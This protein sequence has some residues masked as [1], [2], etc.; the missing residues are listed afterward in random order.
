MKI[1][2]SGKGGAGKTTISAILAKILSS[3]NK[4]IVIDCD[5][6]ANLGETL[7][8]DT[9]SLTPLVEM[10]ELIK[11]RMELSPFGTYKLNPKVSDI[12]DKYFL[13][14]DNIKFMIMG[15]LKEGGSGCYC[16]ENTFIRA[17]LS[18]LVLER[19]EILI[20]DMPAGIEHLTRGTAKGIDNLIIVVEPTSKSIESAKKILKLSEDLRIKKVSI[21]GNKIKD[22]NDKKFILD[23]LAS[24]QI[25]GFLPYDEKLQDLEQ[26]RNIK[27][28]NT[29]IFEEI[30]KI[31]ELFI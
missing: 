4:V 28:E 18:Y 3:E 27:L 14:K 15:V 8:F 1:A 11:E 16:P 21:L 24:F 9:G 26:Q 2:I 17:L 10:K 19:E 6:D 20:L 25:A 31:K 23:N 5:P 29:K 13:E 7:G 22:E 12:P 30:K